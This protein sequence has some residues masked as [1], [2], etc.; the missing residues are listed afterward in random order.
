MQTLGRF[1]SVLSLILIFI[2]FIPLLGFINWIG[3][4]FAIFSLLIA[5]I[6]KSKGSIIICIVAIFIGLLRLMLGG[7]I[8]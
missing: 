4:P 1:F 3:V 2:G 8:L 5:I 7:G 6:G